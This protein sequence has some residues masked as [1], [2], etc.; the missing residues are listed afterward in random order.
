MDCNSK[1]IRAVGIF[2]SLE[3]DETSLKVRVKNLVK[4]AKI[5]EVM[6]RKRPPTLREPS[7]KFRNLNSVTKARCLNY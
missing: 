7:F 1:N 3:V 2:F 4:V 6:G 5:R